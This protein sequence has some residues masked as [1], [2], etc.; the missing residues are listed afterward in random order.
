[1]Q[2]LE[3]VRSCSS[4]FR[5]PNDGLGTALVP[6]VGQ[7]TTKWGRQVWGSSGVPPFLNSPVA[8]VEGAATTP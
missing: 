4:Q 2:G 3:V 6:F 5:H 7:C 8:T 1:M